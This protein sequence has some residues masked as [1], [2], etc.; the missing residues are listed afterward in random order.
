MEPKPLKYKTPE[1]AIQ[2][3]PDFSMLSHSKP[4]RRRKRKGDDSLVWFG[5]V[6]T[7]SFRKRPKHKKKSKKVG[8]IIHYNGC[9]IISQL[10]YC[11]TLGNPTFTHAAP[12][13]W[14]LLPLSIRTTLL[15]EILAIRLI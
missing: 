5:D 6:G 11:C 2:F 8:L 7:T 10:C 1:H 12:V 4:K 14:N 15:H 13:L 9:V 3:S